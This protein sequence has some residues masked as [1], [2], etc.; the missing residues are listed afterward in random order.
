M[1]AWICGSFEFGLGFVQRDVG[2]VFL[3][4]RE[5]D[6]GLGWWVVAPGACG[7]KVGD[8]FGRELCGEGF[9]VELLREGSG[10]VLE[11]DEADENGVV[12]RPWSGLIAEETEL[13]GEMCSLGFHGGVDT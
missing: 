10:E 7:V 2:N 8:E 9:T 4:G 12:G 11:E 3:R 6:D 13:E 5:V 1:A